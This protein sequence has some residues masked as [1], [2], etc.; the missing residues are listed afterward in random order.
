L[1]GE[2]SLSVITDC[3]VQLRAK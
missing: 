2:K 1:S 3:E